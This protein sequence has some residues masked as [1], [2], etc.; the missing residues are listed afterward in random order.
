MAVDL[1]SLIAQ[2]EAVVADPS[3]AGPDRL[4]ILSLA[5]AAAVAVEEPFETV[6]RLAYSVRVSPISISC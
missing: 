1:S 5:R 4:R 2:L 6:Q 3:A